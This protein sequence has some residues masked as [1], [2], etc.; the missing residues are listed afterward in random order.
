MA[1]SRHSKLE[2]TLHLPVPVLP[3]PATITGHPL[4]FCKPSPASG[5]YTGRM[6]VSLYVQL[7]RSRAA[8]A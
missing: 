1:R 7:M 4:E 8:S 5:K 3:Q 6:Y 2:V